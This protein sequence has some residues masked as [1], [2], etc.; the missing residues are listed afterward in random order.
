MTCRMYH[1]LFDVVISL[2]SQSQQYRSNR[3]LVVSAYYI[4]I[5]VL[6]T[7][8]HTTRFIALMTRP[9]KLLVRPNYCRYR[10]TLNML[11]KW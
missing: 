6:I 7:S 4:V 5:R 1:T 9:I 8:I 11:L 10:S 2:Q 3:G